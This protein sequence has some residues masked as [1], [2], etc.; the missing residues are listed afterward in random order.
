MLLGTGPWSGRTLADVAA[1]LGKPFED[2]LI[3]DIDLDDTGAAHF[4]MS[5]PVMERLLADPHVMVCT[6]GSP[7]MRHPRGYGAFARVIRQCVVVSPLLSLE[8]A[9]RKMT[10]LPAETLGLRTRGL[11]APGQ[12]ADILVFDPQTVRDSATF[13]EPHQLAQGFDTV[14]VNGV[15]VRDAGAFTGPRAGRVLRHGID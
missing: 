3:D 12:A 14:L 4:V 1:E 13:E 6:D 9:L 2:V 7:T 8:E 11:I 5:E 15:I 10:G